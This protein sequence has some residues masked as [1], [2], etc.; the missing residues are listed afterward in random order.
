VVCQGF[1]LR[2]I[3]APFKGISVAGEYTAGL[4]GFGKDQ[5]AVEIP[6]PEKST[7]FYALWSP[8]GF[9]DG[10]FEFEIKCLPDKP[11]IPIRIENNILT[12]TVE[13]TEDAT[14]PEGLRVVIT[15]R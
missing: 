5:G 11:A 14:L 10:I 7:T 3:R 8:D 9:R 6:R 4:Y 1:S 15:K 2:Y 12:T 13:V